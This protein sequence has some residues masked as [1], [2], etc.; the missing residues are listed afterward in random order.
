MEDLERDLRI[1][2][3]K[4]KKLKKRLKSKPK[5][6]NFLQKDLEKY[7][8]NINILPIRAGNNNVI[9]VVLKSEKYGIKSF[10]Q[11]RINKIGNQLSKELYDEGFTGYLGNALQ[12]NEYW[13]SGRNTDIGQDI[14]L[15]EQ[16]EYDKDD[17]DRLGNQTKF[18]EARYYVYLND[19]VGKDSKY[20]DCLYYCL[21]NILKEKNPFKKP[22]QL[23]KYLGIPR[24]EGV[25]YR[26][27]PQLEDKL[28]IPINV[29]GDFIVQSKLEGLKQIN[30]KLINGHYTIDHSYNRKAFNVSYTP[31]KIMLFKREKNIRIAYDGL[32]EFEISK[33]YFDDINNFKTDYILV[34]KANGKLSFEEEYKKFKHIADKLKELTKGEID[35]YK[36]GTIKRTALYLFQRLS[37]D[38]PNP[39]AID[40]IEKE[41]IENA[42][43][44]AIINFTKYEGPAY[45]YDIKSQYPSIM[46]SVLLLPI[47][48]GEF[49]TFSEDEFTNL[50]FYPYGIYRVQI[51]KSEDDNIN[52]LFRFNKL[53]YYTHINLTDAQRLGLQINLI[54]DERPNALLYS[55]NKCLRCDQIFKRY[56][57]FL[58]PLKENKTLEKDVRD[59]IKSIINRLWGA[60][61]ETNET[62]NII[63][64]DNMN[65]FQV[66]NN[67]KIKQTK[68]SRNKT[69]VIIDTVHNDNYYKSTFARLKPF[70]LS[71]G[72]SMISTIMQP[73]KEYIKK[74]NTD[75]FISSVKL[76]IKTGDKLGDLVYEGYCENVIIKNNAKPEQEFKI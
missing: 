45:K 65:D 35:L 68:P 52:Q 9:E 19:S 31:R 10:S 37:E 47:K 28:N 24:L 13:R 54:E 58:F 11:S 25:D 34:S 27:I 53:N 72:R 15:Y 4:E 43:I 75:G 39:E 51:S 40:Q 49:K 21:E 59:Y 29:S 8:A 17:F 38:I 64:R 22:Q 18:N 67:H 50:K 2:N 32:K 62:R 63:E 1:L 36:T 6:L 69:Q 55:R 71:K 30:L 5:I 3:K 57:E 14:D 56:I 33:E 74:I 16:G 60:L 20:N 46:K 41:W 26:L 44:G 12:F 66:P 42:G 23:K 61:C 73:H 7:N 70:I 76:D 48:S